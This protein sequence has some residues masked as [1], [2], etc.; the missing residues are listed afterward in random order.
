MLAGQWEEGEEEEKDKGKDQSLTAP[1]GH[2]PNNLK[3]SIMPH[4]FKFLP[5][6]SSVKVE[7]SV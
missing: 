2:A 1:Q 5:P 6:L 4:L 7:P 3:P